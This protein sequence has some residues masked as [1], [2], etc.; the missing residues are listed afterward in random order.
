MNK[1]TL[2]L[3]ALLG[4]LIGM[5]LTL[6]PVTKPAHQIITSEMPAGGDFVLDG[7]NGNVTLSDFKGKVVLLYFGYTFCPDIC[8]TN[9]GYLSAAYQKLSK[10]ERD[11]VQFLM[12]SVDPERDTVNK[13]KMYTDYFEANI[14]GLTGQP[15]YIKELATRYGVVYAKVD[16]P[17]K[18]DFY[19]VDHSAFT[20]IID[21][22][23]HLKEQIP[24][25]T[26]SDRIVETIKKYLN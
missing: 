3:T 15:D 23:G 19:V 10:K 21:Q 6:E 25:A 11:N 20:Y 1:K 24:H 2:I 8:P 13:L 16:I 12:V 26:A 7:P 4:G 14:I 22:N 5:L 18:P 17:Q 9:L